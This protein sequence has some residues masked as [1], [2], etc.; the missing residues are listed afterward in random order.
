MGD[1]MSGQSDQVEYSV[2]RLASGSFQGRFKLPTGER[3]SAGTYVTRKE[4]LE[5]AVAATIERRRGDWQHPAH[6]EAPFAVF[7]ER[8]LETWDPDRAVRTMVGYRSMLR[9]HL[10]PTFGDRS[11]NSIRAIDVDTWYARS[12]KRLGPVALRSSYFLLSGIMRQ[13][14]EW[15]VIRESPC[16]RKKAGRDASQPRPVLT[17]TDLVKIIEA[18]P[19]GLH[20]LLWLTFGAHLRLGEVC[21]LRR[22]DLDL[23]AGTLRSRRTF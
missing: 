3:R 16:R 23:S 1:E 17:V 10:L 19:V 18:H 11:L 9:N 8:A 2:R 6:G 22:S 13:A 14:V 5:A 15:D 4:A 12:A 21:A 20:P 7:A